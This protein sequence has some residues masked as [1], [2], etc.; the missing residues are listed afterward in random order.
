[1]SAR[2]DGGGGL[3]TSTPRHS[4]PTAQDRRA[5]PRAQRHRWSPRELPFRIELPPAGVVL[6]VDTSGM[7]AA[8]PLLVPTR[9]TR[10]GI[11]GEA[12]LARLLAM[13]LLGQSCEL[14]VVTRRVDDWRRLAAGV[15]A[16]PFAIAEQV[17]RWPGDATPPPWALLIDMDEPPPTAFARA[18]WS[19]VVHLAPTAP[20]GSGWWQSAHVVMTTR[21]YARELA[22]LRPRL[23]ASIIDR[24]GPEDVVAVDQSGVTVF[25]PALSQHEYALLTSF[26]GT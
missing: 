18:P 19:T 1:M 3:V 10:V 13:R 6:G 25:R 26:A 12:G 14:T 5:A 9:S 4:S 22:S 7:S 17:R 8:F 23:D 15:P 16:T 2:G 20:H 11:V 21:G 24:L